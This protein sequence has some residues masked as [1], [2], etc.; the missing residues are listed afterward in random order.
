MRFFISLFL[1]L[2]ALCILP[3]SAQDYPSKPIRLIVP[4]APGGVADIIGRLLAP[5]MGEALG[6]TVYVEDRSGAGGVIG[7]QELAKSAPDG[8]S[9]VMEDMAFTISA[10]VYPHLSYNPVKDFT[11]IS[12]VAK[13]PEWLFV[14]ATTSIKSVEDFVAMA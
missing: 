1:A 14:S 3:A 10:W 6:G 13:T 5:P 7:S 9:L 2:Q 8:Y 4:F 12:L 11:P